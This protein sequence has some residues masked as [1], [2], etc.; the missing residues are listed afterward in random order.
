MEKLK[1]RLESPMP[2]EKKIR[3]PEEFIRNPWNIGDIYAY[4]F[5]SEKSEQMGLLGKY[6]PF[7]KLGDVE[8]CD[9]WILS[10]IQI[11][12]RVFDQVI[13][14]ACEFFLL[15]DRIDFCRREPMTIFL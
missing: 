8:W 7:Q 12:D 13:W 10:R 3:K 5:H 15:I 4:Q 9:G 6:I 2:P 11:Y 1:T 14:M